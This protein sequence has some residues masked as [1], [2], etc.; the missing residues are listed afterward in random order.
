ML[1]IDSREIKKK[2]D[3]VKLSH[4]FAERKDRVYDMIQK[5]LERE[6]SSPYIRFILNHPEGQRRRREYVD[7]FEQ[8]LKGSVDVF[9]NDQQQIGYKRAIEGYRLEDVFIFKMVFSQ[10]I[11]HFINEYNTEQEA[12]HNLITFSEI[13]FIEHLIDYSNYLLS[14]SF[15]KTRDEIINHRRNQLHQLHLYAA[16][17]VSIFQEEEL[18]AC[19]NQGIHD[20]FGLNGSFLVPSFPEKD[21][22]SWEGGKLKGLQIPSEFLKG[23]ALEV[24]HSNR[25]I[26]IDAH[27]IILPFDEEMDGDYFKV[28]CIPIHPLNFYVTGLFFVHDQGGTFM[29]EKFD[30]N[31]LYQFCYFTGAVLSNSLMVSQL[32]RKQEE[33]RNLSAQ[34]ISIQEEER[35]RIAADIHDGLTQALT[36]IGYKVLLCQELKNR[37]SSR[38][39]DELNRLVLNINEALR[40]SRQIIS[41]LRPKILDDLGIVA[42]CKRVVN[43]FQENTNIQVDFA[44]PENLEVNPDVGIAFFRILQEALHNIKRHAGASKVDIALAPN[45]K[46]QLCLQLR[47]DGRG[48][49]AHR[50]NRAAKDSGLGLLTM[51]ERA[52]DLGGQFEIISR[53]GEGCHIR[54]IVPL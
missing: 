27:D 42:A 54:V 51:R 20:I 6:P 36:A 35:K 5:G 32:A 53:A 18:R 47:D 43:D 28:I 39:N 10:V 52:R 2:A 46:N 9:F 22:G 29:F 33:L 30:R 7:A 50:Y 15:L 8:A 19:A 1:K 49:N 12:G 24:A 21:L 34:L 26:A 23:V 13:R 45:G 31:L 41:N 44:C 25:A 14:Y 16:K 37:D 48:F 11:W 3:L 4:F 17:A 40:Q 38:L